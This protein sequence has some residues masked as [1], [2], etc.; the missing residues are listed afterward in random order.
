MVAS[1]LGQGELREVRAT[2]MAASLVCR[3]W[4][5]PSQ[6]TMWLRLV[7]EDRMA[8]RIPASPLGG[9]YCTARVVL[10]GDCMGKGERIEGVLEN[11]RGV[12][13]LEL[14]IRSWSRGWEANSADWQRLPSLQ[15]AYRFP[16]VAPGSRKRTR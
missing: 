1:Q 12:E 10:R 2:L 7:V 5:E 4:R 14:S 8:P 13:W 9:K 16:L 3:S 11:L 15:R 6:A